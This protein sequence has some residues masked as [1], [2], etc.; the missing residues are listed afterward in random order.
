MQGA[1]LYKSVSAESAPPEELVV[2]A[3]EGAL[4]Y[5]GLAKEALERKDHIAARRHLARVRS[6]VGELIA[7]LDHESTPEL[8]DRLA[9][10][11]TWMIVELSHAGMDR[12]AR[13]VNNVMRVTTNLLDGFHHAFRQV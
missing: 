12:E 10:I 1:S 3:F 5:Q 11:Y 4:R 8:S 6:I 13:R 7:A 9:Q 2:M